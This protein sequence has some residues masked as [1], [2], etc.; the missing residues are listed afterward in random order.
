MESNLAI[1][2]DTMIP[3][4]A[5]KFSIPAPVVMEVKDIY[6]WKSGRGFQLSKREWVIAETFLKTHN[7]MECMRVVNKE[8]NSDLSLSTIRR[9]LERPHIKVWLGEQMEERG[10]AVGWTEGRW[11][12]VMT[13]HINGVKRLMNGD[14]YAMNLIAKV[15]GFGQ[16]GDGFMIA[17]QINFSER[18]A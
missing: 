1:K 18:A 8:C 4:E 5:P 9:W 2:V 17:Q 12:K 3:Q 11:L 16:S 14:L 7:Y 13:D 10:L 6:V 15:K